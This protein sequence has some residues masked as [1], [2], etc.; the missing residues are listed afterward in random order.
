MADRKRQREINFSIR[1]NPAEYA[2]VQER[3]AAERV[4]VAGV[5]RSAVFQLSRD[6]LPVQSRR[7]TPTPDRAELA[8]IVG[9]LGKVGSNLNQLARNANLGGWPEHDDLT[10]ACTEVREACAA[11]FAALGVDAPRKAGPA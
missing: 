4:S 3:A 10:A 8:R 2:A 9:Q 6:Q 11:I 7:V 5:F 1:L